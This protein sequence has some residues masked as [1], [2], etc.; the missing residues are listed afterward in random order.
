MPRF[1]EKFVD[2]FETFSKSPMRVFLRF[3]A[4]FPNSGKTGKMLEFTKWEMSKSVLQIKYLL[5]CPKIEI[6]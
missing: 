3:P 6:L 1:V 5:A 2:T 4:N